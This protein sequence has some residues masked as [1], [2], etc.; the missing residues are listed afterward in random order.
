[1]IVMVDNSGI[2]MG[3]LC[4]MYPD[5]IG[6]L[7]SPGAWKRP[8]TWMRY[9][10]DNGAYSS[11]KNKKP[12]DWGGFWDHCEKIKQANKKPMWVAVPDVVEDKHSTVMLWNEKSDEVRSKCNSPLAFVV[13]D[14]MTSTD[15]PKN[16]DVVFVGGSTEWKWKSLPIWTKHFPRVHVG[17]VGSER[18]LWMAHDAGAES[19]DGSGWFR[20]GDER[21]VGLENYLHESTFGKKQKYLNL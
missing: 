6:W 19:C 21:R 1:M 20:C 15:V 18:M 4:G 11:F 7:L 12:F 8:P 14:G 17:R 5:R 16:A 3:R 13:Q 10:L 2:E 9:A